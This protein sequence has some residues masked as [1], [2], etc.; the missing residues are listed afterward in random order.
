MDNISFDIDTD[1][2]EKEHARILKLYKERQTAPP[3]TELPPD[4]PKE[5]PAKPLVPLS[6]FGRT[7]NTRATVGP[8]SGTTAGYAKWLKDNPAPKADFTS[9]TRGTHPTNKYAAMG[10]DVMNP[11]PL[12]IDETSEPSDFMKRW[13]SVNTFS[14]D[15]VDDYVNELIK[16]DQDEEDPR[17][18]VNKNKE[19]K[20]NQRAAESQYDMDGDSFDIFDGSKPHSKMSSFTEK[21]KASKWSAHAW[22]EGSDEENDMMS[23]FDHLESNRV[24]D[25]TRNKTTPIT[26]ADDMSNLAILI[27]KADEITTGMDKMAGDIKGLSDDVSEI[28]PNVHDLTDEIKTVQSDQQKIFRKLATMEST[29]SQLKISIDSLST[30]MN[31]I[32]KHLTDDQDLR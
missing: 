9:T 1:A 29:L 11:V 10:V 30:C 32:A 24:S 31:I 17:G 27:D 12:D 6:D 2:I 22:E 3:P 14:D 8:Q 20:M 15:E 16:Y 23:L 26:E 7:S 25:T 13:N 18:K 19:S 4:P 28:A 21:D 5:P